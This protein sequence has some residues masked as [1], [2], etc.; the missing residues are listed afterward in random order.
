MA[1]KV[2]ALVLAICI[3]LCSHGH[4]HVVECRRHHDREHKTKPDYMLLVFG[5]SSVDVGNL[6]KT[7][8]KSRS[9]RAW[10]S[11][12]G[13]SDS[14]HSHS[15]TGRLSDGLLLLLEV[16][17]GF[18]IDVSYLL[19]SSLVANSKGFLAQMLGSDESPPPYRLLRRRDDDASSSGD[20]NFALPFS[21][22]L[23]RG[24][25]EELSLAGQVSQLRRL[26]S[27][28][29]IDD[30]DLDASVALVSLAS[31]HDYSHVN[32]TTGSDD[33][34]DYIQDVTDEVVDTVKRLRDLG[35]DKVVVS[36]MP[37]I[38]CTPWQAKPGY[39]SCYS[40]G[41]TIAST[42]NTLLGQK[43]SEAR[44]GKGDVLLLDLYTAFA[45]VARSIGAGSRPCCAAADLDGGYCGQE[46]AGG[47]ALYS[48]CSSPGSYFYWDYIHPTQAGWKAVMDQLQPT[49]QDFLG[50]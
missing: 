7:S 27:R 3:L 34:N 39:T 35:V 2:A 17:F 14:A 44:F 11:P 13:S 18:R 29:A 6:R 20:V 26:L 10:Y 8:E 15:P 32:D 9:T 24:P 4:H 5:D 36:S 31:A 37:P 23:N 21:G 1:N 46:D 41:N 22:A 48:V 12:Y 50:I 28:G 42:H 43:L 19:V 45:D 25:D 49:I 38:G 47:R 30:A 33:L 16:L 40:T